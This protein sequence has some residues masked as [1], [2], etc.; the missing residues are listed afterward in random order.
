M[1]KTKYT[2]IA[3]AVI[4]AVVFSLYIAF[5]RGTAAKELRNGI[6]HSL[7]ED[8]KIKESLGQI[9]LVKNGNETTEASSNV[10]VDGFY[11]PAVGKKSYET[12]AGEPVMTVNAVK[13]AGVYAVCDGQIE[14]ADEKRISLRHSDGK[15]SIYIGVC[16]TVKKGDTVRRGE[17]IGYAWG[18]INYRIYSACVA[19]DP[20]QYFG[21]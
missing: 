4:L 20:K 10:T 2:V 1:Y 18:K 13:F 8:F 17:P 5:G 11:P 9:F 19:V 21:Q 14:D 16:A 15:K 12:F 7:D 3:A 6:G